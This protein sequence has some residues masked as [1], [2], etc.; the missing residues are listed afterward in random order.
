MSAKGRFAGRRPRLA[1]VAALVGGAATLAGGGFASR[2][3]HARPRRVAILNADADPTA[4]AA[5]ASSLRR[6]LARDTELSPLPAGDL[7]RAL[8]GPLPAQT[9]TARA[10][11]AANKDIQTAREALAHFEEAR[12]LRSLGQAEKALLAA[13]PEPEV[14]ELLAEV[15]FQ[16]GLVHL[17]RQNRGLAVDAFRL[18][19]RLAPDRPPLDPARYPPEV[20][21]AYHEAAGAPGAPAAL[22]VSSTFDGVPVYLDGARVGTTPLHIQIAPGPHYLVVAAPDYVPRGQRLDAIER[23]TIDLMLELDRLPA[24]L[25][26]LDLRRRLMTP[27]APGG[28]SGGQRLRDA[29]RQAAALAGVDAVMVVANRAG[30]VGPQVAV[31]ERAAD[32]LS[33]FRPTGPGAPRLF[34]LLTPAS[35]PDR[36]DLLLGGAGGDSHTPWYSSKWTFASAG[37]VVLGVVAT[38]LSVTA[39]GT[40]GARNLNSPTNLFPPP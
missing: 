26:A 36:A 10:V 9:R 35:L 19:Q 18:A 30:R 39:G 34:G 24:A 40:T 12:S 21:A 7:A 23:D 20:L 27:T 22:T 17:R 15:S 28:G 5:A 3:A 33:L 16:A 37:V 14:V 1:V 29:G 4:G 25:R 13:V 11:A 2:V 6:Q 8:E 31:Y 32:R 38:I